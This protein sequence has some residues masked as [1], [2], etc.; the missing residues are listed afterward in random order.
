V[1]YIPRIKFRY[2]LRNACGREGFDI[3]AG[4][5]LALESTNRHIRR[6]SPVVDSVGYARI[7]NLTSLS[8]TSGALIIDHG[9][10]PFCCGRG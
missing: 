4:A 8:Q 10:E 6:V 9:K 2:K 5:S 3:P 7:V 1:P